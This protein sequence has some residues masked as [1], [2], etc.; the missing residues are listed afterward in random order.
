MPTWRP[1][2]EASRRRA[3]TDGTPSGRSRSDRRQVERA[4]PADPDRQANAPGAGASKALTRVVRAAGISHQISP[5]GLRRTFCT[6]GLV[7]RIDIRDTQYA[8]RHA[9]RAQHCGTT[10]PKPTSPATHPMP[11]LPTSPG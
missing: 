6:S 9:D 4:Y 7:A 1:G 3:Q 2:P 10:C 8:M 11:S 5:H